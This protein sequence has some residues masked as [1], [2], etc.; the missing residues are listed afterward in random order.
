[1]NL[2]TYLHLRTAMMSD[3]DWLPQYRWAQ[4]VKRPTSPDEMALE[5][6]YVVLN[7]GMKNAVAMKIWP[8]IRDALTTQH[9]VPPEVFGHKGK[10]EAMTDIW[11]TSA[12]LFTAM[13]DVPDADL[14][15]WLEERVPYIGPVIKFHA[16]KNL[17]ADVAKPDRWLVRV[18]EKAGETVDALCARLAAGSGD[19]VATVDL[20]IWWAC[21]YHR[22]VP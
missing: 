9:R 10:R 2:D 21:A 11:M 6:C 7:S 3:P 18:A 17:G 5:L 13:K 16:A 1:M 20:V 4:N 8:R 15:D 14:P 12:G 22:H 19:R